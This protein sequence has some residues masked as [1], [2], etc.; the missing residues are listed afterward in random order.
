MTSH[1][2]FWPRVPPVRDVLEAAVLRQLAT[3]RRGIHTCHEGQ[4]G[5]KQDMHHSASPNSRRALLLPHRFDCGGESA[6]HGHRITGRSG[7]IIL[8]GCWGRLLLSTTH[9]GALCEQIR[10]LIVQAGSGP[11]HETASQL[12]TCLSPPAAAGAKGLSSFTGPLAAA[13]AAAC[14]NQ[15]Y[16]RY[17]RW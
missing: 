10:S 4:A 15:Q 6:A 7:S 5:S 11:R 17:E 2:P 14:H 1:L 8:L 16:T 9:T 3:Q 12:R 13:A